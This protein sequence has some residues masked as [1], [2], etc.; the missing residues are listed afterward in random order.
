LINRKIDGL[1]NMHIAPP[2]FYLTF[3][4]ANY[5]TT[6]SLYRNIWML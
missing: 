6:I 3:F 2:T 5:L 4:P 1:I